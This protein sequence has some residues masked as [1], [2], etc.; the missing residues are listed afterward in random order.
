MKKLISF[1]MLLVS[2]YLWANTCEWPQWETFKSVYME[3]GRVVDGSDKRMI[4]TS[5]G[6]SYALFFALVA[7]DPKT[8]DQV[9]KWT[10]SHLAGGDL[11]ARL[12]AWLWGRK[13]NG[14]F[15]VLDSNP[16]SDSDLWIAYSLVEAGRL[17]NNY[18]YQT[19]GHLIASR[20][21][22]EETVNVEGV[23]TVLLPAP[24]GFGA[25]GQY[26]VNPSYVPLQLIARMQSLYP[27]YNWDSMYKASVHML[28]KTMPAG[29]SP[30]WAT[31]RNG[32]YSSDGV[33]GPI[34]SYNA[35]RTY[36]WVGMLN[37]QVSEKAVLVQKMQPFVAATKA[38]GAPARE[39]NTETGKYTQAGSA[40]FSAA[41]LPLL[42]AS[43]ESALLEAQFS[44]AQNEL[45]MDKNDH[46]YDNVLSLFGLGWHAERYR[47]GVQGELLPAWSERCQ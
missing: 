17:W 44:R 8:F 9:L 5:E 16:A 11:T 30:D 23:G 1:L 13:E 36:L 12:P 37:D 39:V 33:T 2:P 19:L 4:T 27:Q 45:V 21:L 26:R 43:G 18:Y 28:E 24:T 14:Q 31:L 15:G 3:Q 35:I 42:A 47:F 40:G 29:F 7:N 46:Y 38:L 34:G 22:R 32:R 10:Q 41:A 6:Q 25:D 20:I